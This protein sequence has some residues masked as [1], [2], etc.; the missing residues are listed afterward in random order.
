MDH[1]KDT[2]KTVP[3][4]YAE[5]LVKREFDKQYGHKCDASPGDTLDFRIYYVNSKAPVQFSVKV[6]DILPEGLSYV[7]GSLFAITPAVP[8]GVSLGETGSKLFSDRGL[9]IGDFKQ[10]EKAC[11][12]YQAIIRKDIDLGQQHTATFYN[13][14]K[15]ATQHGT[16]FSK[17]LITVHEV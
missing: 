17:A 14:T 3:V 9:V 8:N 7:P 15:V 5:Q 6:L 16:V 13:A 1:G 2:Q 12:F 11:L 4:F 10:G